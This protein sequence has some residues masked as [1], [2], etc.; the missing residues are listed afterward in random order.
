MTDRE[1]IRID[2]DSDEDEDLRRAIALSLQDQG[3]TPP[4]PT[5]AP[6]DDAAKQ[7]IT[8]SEQSSNATTGLLA[9][10]RKQMEQERLQ[11]LAKRRR[12]SNG[13]NA[14]PSQPPAKRQVTAETTIPSPLRF[15]KGAVKR[16]WARGYRRTS[17]D[18][19]IEEVFQ[20]DE[21]QLAILSSFQWDE[22]W[23]L[24]KLDFPRTKLMLLAFAASEDQ[25]RS[26]TVVYH[27]S[28]QR[29]LAQPCLPVR[30]NSNTEYRSGKCKIMC[31]QTSGSASHQ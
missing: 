8:E 5:Y 9:L 4:Q 13:T 29:S 20:K 18:I 24:S 31:R 21:L 14:Q 27:S 7:P 16:T 1:V 2:S 25:V 10:D 23:M 11:R 15:P 22:E 19:T 28:H 3:G 6:S 17:D 12:L 30:A 26:C